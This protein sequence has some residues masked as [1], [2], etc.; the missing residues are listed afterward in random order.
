MVTGQY[1]QSG[2]PVRSHAAQAFKAVDDLAQIHLP[3]MAAGIALVKQ[4]KSGVVT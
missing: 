3:V 2:V 4:L 1:G